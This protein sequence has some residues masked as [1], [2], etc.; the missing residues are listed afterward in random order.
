LEEWNVR[1]SIRSELSREHDNENMKAHLMHSHHISSTF[2]EKDLDEVLQTT[3]IFTNV[4]KGILAKEKDLMEAFGT[5]DEKAICLEI[6]KKGD[7]QVRG[8]A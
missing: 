3:T 4:S 8:H 1:S 2:S 6:L 7:L 5:T